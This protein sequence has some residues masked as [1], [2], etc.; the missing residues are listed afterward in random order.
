VAATI[1]AKPP[2][3]WIP[4]G[5]AD[6][7]R[8]ELRHAHAALKAKGPV[9]DLEFI[10][11]GAADEAALIIQF[12]EGD[13]FLQEVLGDSPQVVIV[14]LGITWSSKHGLQFSG[15]VKLDIT[16]PVHAS[17]GGVIDFDSITI[18]VGG[19][20][21]P[22][23]ISHGISVTGGLN[24]GP[25]S[26]TVDRVGLQATLAPPP[27]GQTAGNIGPLN[28]GFGFLPPKGLGM[29]IDAGPVSGGG[30][31]LF[32]QDA[33]RYAGILQLTLPILS[34]TAIG[35]LDTKLPGGE[36]GYSFLIIL[37]CDFPPIQLGYGFVL[38]GLG[39]L[40]GINRSI[41]VKALQDGVHSGSVDSPRIRSRM[42][43]S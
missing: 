32:D 7:I 38:T 15:Q 19:S 28:L 39:G 42:P 2:T 35:L 26:A 41:V 37:T 25:V 18:T 21:S 1:D 4:I 34:I 14:G 24:I 6:S 12:G 40:A 8:L 33:G 20:T 22:M 30:Y 11:E 43:P 17:I 9:Q 10:I 13:G 31:I 29:S 23:G 16:I 27:A 36:T 5:T 3:P